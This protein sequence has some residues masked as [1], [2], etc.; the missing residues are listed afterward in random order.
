MIRLVVLFFLICFPVFAITG[1]DVMTNVQTESRKNSTREAVV[2]ML[3][4]DDKGRKRERYFNYWTKFDD[5][6]EQSLIK[7]F[8]P[9]NIKGT[10]LLTRS[11]F[12]Q[13]QKFQWIYL[14][15]FKSVKQL[16]STDKNKNFMGSDFSYSD[17]AGRK[18]S[19]DTHQLIKETPTN[20]YIESIPVD[21]SQSSYSKIRY[22]ISKEFNVII[23]AIFY[24]LDG[25]KLKTLT[26]S[27]VSDNNGVYI[28]MSSEMQNHQT[29]G[30]TILNVVSMKVGYAI[31]DDFFS[32][33]G[34]KTL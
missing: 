1:L 20:Y 21:L 19:Q 14:P 24:D 29:N 15:A 25:K 2:D 17:I 16:S 6:S 31:K 30:Q 12:K 9:K 34:L 22:I 13:D 26:N 32:V 3:I 33:E 18:L 27:K 10:A 7:F 8:K 4:L 23:K 11:D 28:V 5:K